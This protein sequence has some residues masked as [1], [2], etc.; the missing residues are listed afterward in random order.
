MNSLVALHTSASRGR[1]LF[2]LTKI[3][4]KT[5]VLTSSP[6]ACAFQ[7]APHP[8][9]LCH[10]CAGPFHNGTCSLC[11]AVG[12]SGDMHRTLRSHGWQ[13]AE[14][15][16]AMVA[17]E[18][19]FPV[20]AARIALRAARDPAILA[21]VDDLVLPDF[22][23]SSW[24]DHWTELHTITAEAMQD[25]ASEPPSY[26]WLGQTI[27]RCHLNA[28]SLGT[29]SAL[30][31][32]ASYLNHSCQPNVALKLSGTAHC[33]VIATRAIDVGSELTLNYAQNSAEDP[34][35]LS[36]HLQRTYGIECDLSKDSCR[37]CTRL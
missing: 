10:F 34:A 19:L 8:P 33:D 12:V 9:A 27:L 37:G 21:A 15:A 30:Y 29:T 23:E 25:A 17:P 7:R 35:V 6:L 22:P 4:P 28:I 1:G 36:A 13:E 24:P 5:I 26:E 18:E 14:R 32:E 11:A 3:A 2:A 20:I 16:L 31:R